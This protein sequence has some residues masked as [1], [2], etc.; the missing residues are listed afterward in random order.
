MT[1]FFAEKIIMAPKM[2][3]RRPK[4][5]RILNYNKVSIFNGNVM[6]KQDFLQRFLFT[7]LGV[8]GEWV[9]LG[10]SWQ[11]A[12]QHQQG[13]EVVQQL[14]GQAL[15][16][17]ALLSATVKF[18]GSMILQAQGEGDIK[19]LVAQ[20]T[21]DRKIRG[22]VRSQ[23]DVAEGRLEDLFGNGRLVLTIEM[24]DSDPYQGIVALAGENLA[25]ALENYF[26]QSEQL[27]TRL[28][29]FANDTHA[30]GLLLQELPAQ[31]HFQ[32]DWEHI[33]ILASTVTG[34]E[35]LTLDCEAMLYRLFNQEKLRLFDAEPVEFQCACSQGRIERTL[36]ALGRAELHDMLCEQQR[37]EVVCEFCGAQ[38]V[39]DN[40]DVEGFLAQETPGAPSATHH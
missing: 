34:P 9:K 19:T 15:A 39:F 7:E 28:W 40:V 2:S 36:R 10:D 3:V 11:A 6:I 12:K 20:S 13:S 38:Y 18:K 29:L 35:L 37:I 24:A 30:A 26:T 31:P 4:V 33:E 1:V 16:A 23:P 27:K 25:A 22:L 8:R 14:L 5:A 21:H 32:A 17:V